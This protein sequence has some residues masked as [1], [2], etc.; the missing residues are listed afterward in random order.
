MCYSFSYLQSGK[1]LFF[2]DYGTCF[3]FINNANE[4]FLLFSFSFCP[5]CFALPVAVFLHFVPLLHQLQV[6]AFQI[7]SKPVTLALYRA[8]RTKERY[9]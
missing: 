9:R 7:L 1:A 4:A 8:K 5:S 2:A 6:F 3:L